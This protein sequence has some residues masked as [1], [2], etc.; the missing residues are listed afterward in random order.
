MKNRIINE[1]IQRFFHPTLEV[2][3]KDDFCESYYNYV[4][5]KLYGELRKSIGEVAAYLRNFYKIKRIP[6]IIIFLYPD[7]TAMNEAF[8]RD[9]PND[10]C[11]FAPIKG[12]PSL[13]TFTSKIG[14]DNLKQVLSHEISHIIFAM[15]SGNKEVNDI[16]QTKPVWLDEGLALLV[17]SKFRI[18][19]ENIEKKRLRCLQEPEINYFP[20]LSELNTYFNRIDGAVEFGPKGLMAYAYSYFCVSKLAN[21]F[22][23]EVIVSFVKTLSRKDN[24]NDCFYE[25]FGISLEN[26]NLEMKRLIQTMSTDNIKMGS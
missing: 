16:Q 15:L 19:L 2:E 7:I 1:D 12:N 10:Q 14:K 13:I 20:N 11:C 5:S 9:L 26:F 22:K 17:D 4:D 18:N 24:F 3:A 23:N 6:K 21:Q 25:Y 8:Q